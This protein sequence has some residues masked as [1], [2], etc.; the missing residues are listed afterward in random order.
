MTP[1]VGSQNTLRAVTRKV[2]PR[3]RNYDSDRS[4]F[5]PFLESLDSKRLDRVSSPIEQVQRFS[6]CDWISI[7]QTHPFALPVLS[8]G[9]FL[10][11]DSDG[12][13]E[14]T[15]LKK[16]RI[17]GSHESAVFVRCDGATVHFE[18]NV[19]KLGRPDN[20]F[21]YSFA[22]CIERINSLLG[23]LGLPPFSAGKRGEVVSSD[24]SWQMH[25]TGARIT[26]IDLT[27]N[28]A[29]GSKADANH[30]MRY[31][32]MQQASRLKTGTY[33]EGE[34]VDFGRGSKYVYSK[35]Y[36]KGPELL[37]HAKRNERKSKKFA[38]QFSIEYDPYLNELADWCN[39]T[40]LVRFETTYKARWLTQNSHQF[41]GSIDMEQLEI[42]FLE[43][44]S[45]LSRADTEIDQMSDL[46]AK[47]L[48]VYRMWQAGDDLTTK[49]K[50]SSFYKH[51]SRLLPYGVDIAIKSNIVKFEPRTRVIQL[52]PVSIP[53]F[54]QLPP[55]S[56]IRLA[57]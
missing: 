8:D 23:T 46:D 3:T 29:A 5:S 27:R 52:G 30:F 10:R 37:T 28:F 41:L 26:R 2:I 22:E 54:Y 6:F 55:P 47:T 38:T 31:L 56:F 1:A 39:A 18:G 20:V 9:C 12:T 32:A 11:F 57:A 16:L 50:K 13:H 24:G 42:D 34:T 21:G 43:R 45:L 35:A 25:W 14:S 36:L 15:T 19:S 51:R 53:D 4:P 48:A 44:Q 17:E 7:Y 40:G 33:G 49:F